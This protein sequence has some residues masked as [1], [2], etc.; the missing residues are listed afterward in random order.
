MTTNITKLPA[1]CKIMAKLQINPIDL[2]ELKK[3]IMERDI[4]NYKA[5]MA[6][7]SPIIR[8]HPLTLGFLDSVETQLKN[9]EGKYKAFIKKA[10]KSNNY[11]IK[12]IEQGCI[13]KTLDGRFMLYIEYVN[14]SGFKVNFIEDVRNIDFDILRKIYQRSHASIMREVHEDLLMNVLSLENI[15]HWKYQLSSYD[16]FAH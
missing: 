6:D 1:G 9:A 15:D 8:V 16:M 10:N 2:F 11:F 12:R 7:D 14:P 3:T 5:Y 4:K 13:C